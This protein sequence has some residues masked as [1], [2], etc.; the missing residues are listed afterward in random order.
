MIER[1]A[2]FSSTFHVVHVHVDHQHE[3]RVLL[4]LHLL[5]ILIFQ[6]PRMSDLRV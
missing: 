2:G 3:R 4:Q 1:D 6:V 5:R